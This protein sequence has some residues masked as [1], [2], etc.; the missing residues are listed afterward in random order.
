MMSNSALPT[1]GKWKQRLKKKPLLK[2]YG[3]MVAEAFLMS[4]MQMMLASNLL[5]PY[6]HNL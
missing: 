5:D 6:L 1:T 4:F 3:I 2:T